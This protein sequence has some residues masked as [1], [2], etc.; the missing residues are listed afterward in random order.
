MYI[1]LSHPKKFSADDFKKIVFE[2]TKGV[3]EKIKAG[4]LEQPRYFTYEAI[5]PDIV[6][7]L[8]TSF[9]FKKLE[10]TATWD[11]FGWPS[12]LNEKHWPNDRQSLK[13][14]T[15]YLRDHGF[16]SESMNEE[17]LL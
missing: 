9:G 10:Y 12:I 4:K 13:E 2:A 8:T 16:T 1:Q 3:L 5:F 14:L 11:C 6:R 17:Q 15:E 7:E